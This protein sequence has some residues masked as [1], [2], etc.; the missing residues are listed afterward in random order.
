MEIPIPDTSAIRQPVGDIH[1][2]FAPEWTPR[3]QAEGESQHLSELIEQGQ[4]ENLRLRAGIESLEQGRQE[5]EGLRIR[6]AEEREDSNRMRHALQQA[7]EQQ[8]QLELLLFR[9]DASEGTDE[10]EEAEEEEADVYPGE[11]PEEGEIN[12]VDEEFDQTGDDSRHRDWLGELMRANRRARD[13]RE[14]Q[15]DSMWVTM[16]KQQS[17]SN[18]LKRHWTS[19][20]SRDI[21]TDRE[22][23]LALLEQHTRAGGY[24]RTFAEILK[25]LMEVKLQLIGSTNKCNVLGKSKPHQAF[26]NLLLDIDSIGKP[27]KVFFLI[28]ITVERN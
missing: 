12:D 16:A 9:A 4:E 15:S 11:E 5:L 1:D 23:V 24:Q 18:Y 20:A 7:T 26:S 14:E 6:L 28:Y 19:W 21:E 27:K 2:E 13:Q 10:V 3:E 17:S 25:S 8:K 22:R